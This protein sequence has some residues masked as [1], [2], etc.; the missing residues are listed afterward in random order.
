M[1]KETFLIAD[2]TCIVYESEQPE[3]L[4]LQP[5][6]EHD[7]EVLDNEAAVIQS[8]TSRPFTLV[9]ASSRPGRRLPSSERC[10]SAMGRRRRFR[11]SRKR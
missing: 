9:R 3:F 6:D 11:S 1:K 4:L 10:L 5:I 7:L 8:L 2:R